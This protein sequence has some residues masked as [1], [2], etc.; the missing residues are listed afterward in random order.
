MPSF[1]GN[2]FTQRHEICSQETRDSI[3]PGLESVLGR[4]RRT[5]G[6]TELRQ[7]IR[8]KHYVLLRVKI[9]LKNLYSRR[10][11]RAGQSANALAKN[12]STVDEKVVIKEDRQ[13]VNSPLNTPEITLQSIHRSP[14]SLCLT[15]SRGQKLT[16]ANRQTRTGG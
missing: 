4:D 7:L 12:V 5:E 6:Q 15:R 8:A 16:E 2:L 9:A 1:D 14:S 10:H 3:S 13:A 11:D